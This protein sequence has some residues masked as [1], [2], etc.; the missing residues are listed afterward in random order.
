MRRLYLDCDGVLAD[1]E[2]RFAEIMAADYA[3]LPA[4]ASSWDWIKLP[5]RNYD[6]FWHALENAKPSFYRHLKPMPDAHELVNAVR[7]LRPV[8]LTG[9]PRGT[10]AHAQKIEW[11]HE[12][13]PGLPIHVCKSEE[14]YLYCEPGDVLVDDWLKYRELWEKAGGVWITHRSARESAEQVQKAFDG[15][16]WYDPTVGC[17]HGYGCGC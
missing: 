6:Q 14:K 16:F 15:E 12:H 11:A 3:T 9:C 1:F 10:W 2:G 7:H 4:G 17:V 5:G 13:F 8:I